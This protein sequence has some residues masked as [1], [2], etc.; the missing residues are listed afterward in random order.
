MVKP[1]P[2]LP[3]AAEPRAK[4]SRMEAFQA[5]SRES[6]GKSRKGVL[7]QVTCR[8]RFWWENR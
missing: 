5:F 8:T 7:P 2:A 3:D 1:F 6:A 4:A